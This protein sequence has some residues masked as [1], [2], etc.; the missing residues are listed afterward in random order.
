MLGA[1]RVLVFRGADSEGDGDGNRDTV[2]CMLHIFSMYWNFSAN[3]HVI[4]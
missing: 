3:F 1:T 2:A 4:L